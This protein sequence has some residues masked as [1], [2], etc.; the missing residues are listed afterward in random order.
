MVWRRSAAE[1]KQND[2]V[3]RKRQMMQR[4]DWSTPIGILAYSG[5]EPVAWAS[6]AP[7]ETYRNLGGPPAETGEVIWSLVCF[8]V[9]RRLRGQGIMRRLIDA[10]I[11]HART[12]GATIVE[13]YPV[14][15]DAPS[16]RFMGF[17]PIFAEAGFTEVGRTGHRRHVMRLAL[18]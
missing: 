8:F 14:D 17:V 4:L 5:E 12:S 3:G 2:R 1:A 10:A 16:Y 13:A 7:R 15:R 6:I 11:D 18:A 9:P